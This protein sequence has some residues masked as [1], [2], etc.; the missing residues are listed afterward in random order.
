M[1]I[2]EYIRYN[3]RALLNREVRLYRSQVP[4][5]FR[6]LGLYKKI[7][8]MIFTVCKKDGDMNQGCWETSTKRV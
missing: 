7:E 3:H 2:S 8:V 1:N 6:F 4:D 5:Y